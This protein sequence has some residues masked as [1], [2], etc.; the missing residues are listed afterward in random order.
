MVHQQDHVLVAHRRH[1]QL[2]VGI[3]ARE[4]LPA[5]RRA[6]CRRGRREEV[7]GA[8]RGGT[9]DERRDTERHL[10]HTGRVEDGVSALLRHTGRV[11]KAA[12]SAAGAV[13][14]DMKTGIVRATGVSVRVN[15]WPMLSPKAVWPMADVV[16]RG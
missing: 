4:L 13:A 12:G 7:S 11:R 3:A 10:L 1:P 15:T 14:S 9:L 5:E 6:E 8:E 2:E 16:A